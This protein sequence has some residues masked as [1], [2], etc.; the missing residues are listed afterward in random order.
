THVKLFPRES[1]QGSCSGA[2]SGVRGASACSLI[3][4]ILFGSYLLVFCHRFPLRPQS[5]RFSGSLE[6]F[7]FLW[8][9]TV[10]RW[11]EKQHRGGAG[12]KGEGAAWNNVRR[13][14]RAERS[15]PTA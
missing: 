3:G 12:K 8:C 4:T 5:G 1:L 6:S 13:N 14:G 7:L 9:G 2:D 10:A 15:P 11:T